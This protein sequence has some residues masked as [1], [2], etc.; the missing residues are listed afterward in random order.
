ME[1]Q[2][3]AMMFNLQTRHIPTP[4]RDLQVERMGCLLELL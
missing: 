1:V 4:V 3:C 2:F